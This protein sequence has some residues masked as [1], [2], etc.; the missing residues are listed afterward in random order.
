VSSNLKAN[1]Q[2]PGFNGT[3]DLWVT[4]TISPGARQ[5]LEQRGYRIVER[6][7]TRVEILD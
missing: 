1:Y 7:H 5:E 4:G 6:I 3:F 2:R